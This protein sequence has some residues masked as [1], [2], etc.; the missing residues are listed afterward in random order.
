MLKNSVHRTALGPILYRLLQVEVEIS[1]L[2]EERNSLEN[3]KRELVIA[4]EV[5]L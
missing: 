3:E 5:H 2:S 1:A 4:K